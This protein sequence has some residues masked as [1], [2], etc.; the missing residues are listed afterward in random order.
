[1][2]AFL[3]LEHLNTQPPSVL[4]SKKDIPIFYLQISTESP[5]PNNSDIPMSAPRGWRKEQFSFSVSI[6]YFFLYSVFL[7]SVGSLQG[8]IRNEYPS[9]MWRNACWI[10]E[11]ALG[12]SIEFP[13]T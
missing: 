4:V 13:S 9:K 1:M 3:P 6:A 7:R 12:I 11:I 2:E 10:K 8:I 5:S